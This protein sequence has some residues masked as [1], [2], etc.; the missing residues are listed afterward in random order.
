MKKRVRE[1]LVLKR[2]VKIFMT[3]LMLMVI[4]FLVGLIAIRRNNNL[5]EKI[6][7]EVYTKS[8]KFTK[9]R[10]VYNKYFGK[11]LSLDKVVQEEKP[12]F[13]EKLAYKS[14]AKYKNGVKLKVDS[15]YLVPV[16]ESGI[17]VYVGSKDNLNTIIVEQVDGIDTYYKNID[18]S[19]YKLYDYIEKGQVLGQTKSNEL[20]LSF[21]KD[22][23]FLDY[24]KYI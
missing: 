5:K 24:K 22:G 18:I 13:S 19:N 16:L 4:I 11:V 12:V 21:E 10:N 8:F 20:Y 9:A 7:E 23:E 17:I 14:E 2:H 6:N 15:N 3:K 1:H